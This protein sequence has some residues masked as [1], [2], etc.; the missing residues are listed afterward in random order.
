ML[1]SRHLV[2]TLRAETPNDGLV[3]IEVAGNLHSNVQYTAIV[4]AAH[5]LLGQLGAPPLSREILKDN[6]DA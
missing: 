4:M 3:Y 5:A 2:L 6:P 1:S